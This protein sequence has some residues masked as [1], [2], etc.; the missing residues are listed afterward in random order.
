MGGK[1]E[2]TEGGRGRGRDRGREA[3]RREEARGGKGT[4]RKGKG[5]K[6]RILKFVD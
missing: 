4:E 5:D 1:A 2:A 3:T 6:I